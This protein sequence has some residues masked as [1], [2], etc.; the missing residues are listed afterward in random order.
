MTYSI[1]NL[2]EDF[3]IQNLDLSTGF[4]K[5]NFIVNRDIEELDIKKDSFPIELGVAG[6][7]GV[8][9]SVVAII[10]SLV[11]GIPKEVIQKAL[12]NFK[13]VERRF[14]IIYDD[15]FTIIDDHYANSRNIS[16]T[17]ETIEKMDY[18]NL[19]MLY[20]IRGNRGVNLNR[21]SAEETAKWL[22]RLNVTKIYSTSSEETV[23]WKDEV[24]PEEIDVFFEIM[25]KNHI[26]FEHHDRL[27]EAI[28]NIMEKVEEKDLLLLAGCQG[29][30]P[31]GRILLEKLS[32]NFDVGKKEAVL[33]VLE[34]RAF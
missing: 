14:Q 4:A 30:D 8:M 19:Y 18:N 9:N 25:D 17:L 11:R 28:Y 31:G 21:E 15:G 32:E 5:F 23:T 1:K 10:I 2:E 3:G 27:D 7:S 16:V 22:K 20:A 24:S 34:G 29:M 13:G 6:Y 26:A 12:K 33:K